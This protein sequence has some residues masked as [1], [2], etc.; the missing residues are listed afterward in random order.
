MGNLNSTLTT[1]L[2]I[3]LTV[4]NIA[5]FGFGWRAM[6]RRSPAPA[7]AAPNPRPVEFPREKTEDLL[8]VA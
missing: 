1:F 4:F 6:I 2:D 5:L 7:P 3:V 8:P